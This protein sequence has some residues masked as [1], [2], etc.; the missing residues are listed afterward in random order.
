LNDCSWV[1]LRIGSSFV[2]LMDEYLV[3]DSY[4][5]MPDADLDLK[6][7][8]LDGRTQATLGDDVSY[9]VVVANSGRERLGG[10]LRVELLTPEGEVLASR[11]TEVENLNSSQTSEFKADFNIDG[12]FAP[13]KTIKVRATVDVDD[14]NLNN[15]VK[16]LDLVLMNSSLPLV[17]DLKAEVNADGNVELNWSP[18]ET[19]YGD[20]ENF[21]SYKPFAVTETFDYWRNVN[22]DD[23]WPSFFQNQTTGTLVRWENDNKKIGWQVY[24]WNEMYN[25]NEDG[26]V[27][28]TPARIERLKPHSGNQALIAR[29]AG[30]E[31]GSE[32]VATSKWLVSPLV[33]PG[34]SFSFYYT[35]FASDMTEYIEIWTCEKENGKFNAEDPNISLGRAGDFKKKTTK[36]KNG[37]EIWE[38]VTYNLGRKEC[39]FAL[40]YVS[41]D[42]YA[43]AI[44]DLSFTPA[45]MLTRKADS[46]SVYRAD[47]NGENP[48]LIAENI[49]DTSFVDTNWN[50]TDACYYVVSNSMVDGWLRPSPISNVVF[51]GSSAVGEIT[52]AQRVSAGFGV[53]NIENFAGQP[54]VIA[55][56]DGKVVVSGNATSNYHSYAVDK[57]IYLVTAGKK[58]YKVV[59]K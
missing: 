5:I 27:Y 15:N 14:E 9:N 31:E 45:N 43:A 40:R 48:V 39:Y 56:T 7:S 33:K 10:K 52:A 38:L 36:S 47:I 26:T 55:A 30:Y 19:E 41:Y 6:V 12:S 51:I 22:G 8:E 44:D 2:G 42:G 49:T 20:F 34:T 17:T 54:V 4:T 46:Y 53:I 32:P 24:D 29:T 57:G 3:L 11:S 58:T 35:T 13:Y 1:Q 18:A 50:D 28:T 23:L 25:T 21:E 37:S 59:V 16:E